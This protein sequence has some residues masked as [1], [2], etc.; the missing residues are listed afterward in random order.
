MNLRS[1]LRR[2]KTQGVPTM[3][4][5][6]LTGTTQV[7]DPETGTVYEADADGAFEMPEDLANLLHSFHV[8]GKPAWEDDAERARRVAAE[9]LEKM[10]DPAALLA[11]VQ[12]LSA[13]QG[14]LA[15]V[16][17]SALGTPAPATEA[18]PA[19]PSQAPEPAPVAKTA[20][21]R[22]RKSAAAAE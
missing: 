9:Q 2:T 22:A 19:E 6:T 1:L 3:R 12:R 17:A 10:R 5:Y 13:N 11:E 21:P 16:L 15:A 14:A 20:K 18:A 8:A 7:K 4:L